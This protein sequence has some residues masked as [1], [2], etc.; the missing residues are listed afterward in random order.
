MT[1]SPGTAH[2]TRKMRTEGSLVDPSAQT[3]SSAGFEQIAMFPMSRAAADRCGER[4]VSVVRGF[5]GLQ[6]A[7]RG[8]LVAAVGDC[9]CV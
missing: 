6:W 7:A 9:G 8:E 3:G 1:I 4:S 5:G 2:V